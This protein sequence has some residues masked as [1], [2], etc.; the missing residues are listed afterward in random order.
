QFALYLHSQPTQLTD[1]IFGRD[2][3]FYLFKLPVIELVVGWLHTVSV[4]M[5]IAIA[6]VS[7]YVWYFEQV[8]GTITQDLRQRATTAISLAAAFFA[9]TLAASTYL[10]RFDLL[11]GQHEIFTGVDYTDAN[12]RLIAMNIL[13][14]LLI[15]STV[16]L[17]TNAF[18][19]KRLKTIVSLVVVVG[20]VWVLG[21]GIIPSTFH[22][23]SVKPNELAKE[24]P[25]IDHNIKMTRHAFGI[26]R[27]EP[28]DEDARRLSFEDRPFEPKAALTAEQV[29]AN[30]ETLDNVRL[31]D[32]R[33]LQS[34]LAQIQE[35]RTYYD[36]RLPDVDRYK[37]NGRLRQ[38]MLSAREMNVDQLPDQSRNWIN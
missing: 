12:V 21:L 19:K 28:N 3:S 37:I 6:A 34:T 20:V 8:R 24:A 18:F 31:W 32:R 10:D 22:S 36:F 17:V 2:V 38:V 23:F 9:L 7:G 16:V 5:F 27:L 25:F 33:A 4:V 11:H 14:G 29:Q 35:I 1:P 13:I 26:D 15:V 30:R